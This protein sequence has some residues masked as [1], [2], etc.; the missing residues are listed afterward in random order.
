MSRLR[1]WSSFSRFAH[2][3]GPTSVNGVSRELAQTV[4]NRI[5]GG[6]TRRQLAIIEGINEILFE[7][8]KDDFHP[9]SAACIEC[10]CY[11][12]GRELSTPD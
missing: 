7:M 12:I 10:Q 5:F 2:G 9:H 1:S 3:Y 6:W 8:H 4:I 11:V